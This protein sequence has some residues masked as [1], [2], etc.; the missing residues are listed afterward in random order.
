ML[1]LRHTRTF[2][3][4][5]GPVEFEARDE[6]GRPYLA[7]LVEYRDD[8]DLFIVV[9]ASEDEI[10]AIA[11]GSADTRR[12]FLANGAAAWY[13]S[14]PHDGTSSLTV[15]AQSGPIAAY[16]NRGDPGFSLALNASLGEISAVAST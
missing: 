7:G 13:L 4:L 2:T 6:A 14:E 12:L 15:H 10:A 8:G 16:E 5:D 1:T 3:Y 11:A 9:P